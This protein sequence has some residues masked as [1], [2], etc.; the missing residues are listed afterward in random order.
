[1]RLQWAL[2]ISRCVRT[3]NFMHTKNDR[4]QNYKTMVNS[5][6]TIERTRINAQMSER[7]YHNE[8]VRLASANEAND[9][10][11]YENETKCNGIFFMFFGTHVPVMHISSNGENLAKQSLC[12]KTHA[13]TLY[14]C[15]RIS[16]RWIAFC[17]IIKIQIPEFTC[18]V[19]TSGILKICWTIAIFY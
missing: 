17:R 11:N 8:P 13:W 9:K 7:K 15:T 19:Q 1:M 16:N 5:Y 2:D 10:K 4:Y 6:W 12:T 14:A 18:K 3:Q